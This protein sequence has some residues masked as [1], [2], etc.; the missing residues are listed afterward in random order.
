MALSECD[1]PREP[2][3][4][5][6]LCRVC[7]PSEASRILPSLESIQKV[8]EQQLHPGTHQRSQVR[9][10][11]GGKSR[12]GVWVAVSRGRDGSGVQPWPV[13]YRWEP[14]FLFSLASFC[15]S[16]EGTQ[17]SVPQFHLSHSPL[18]LLPLPVLE[19]SAISCLRIP[20]SPSSLSM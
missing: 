6:A 12:T 16:A 14:P 5:L 9:G 18:H 17:S 19:E 7:V 2:A 13:E 8:F 11:G 4:A 15:C 20:T 1:R 10:L 3:T